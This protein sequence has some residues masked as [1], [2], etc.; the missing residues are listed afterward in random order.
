MN[1]RVHVKKAPPNS[2]FRRQAEVVITFE[3]VATFSSLDAGLGPN[4]SLVPV[5]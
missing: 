2:S 5:G 4:T 3:N 1:P